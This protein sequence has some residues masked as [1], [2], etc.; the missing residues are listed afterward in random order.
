MPGRTRPAT[1]TPARGQASRADRAVSDPQLTPMMEQYARLKARA[2]EALLFFRMGDFYELFHDD[3]VVAAEALNITLTSRQKHQGEP[4]PMCGVPYHSA[5]G[6]LDRLLKQGMK[7]A[8]AEQVEDPRHADGLVKRDIIRVVTPG[9]VVSANSLD[10]KLH[11]FLACI[12]ATPSGAGFA[13]VDISTGTFAVT[14]WT[15]GDSWQQP[16]RAEYERVQ[17]REVLVPEPL[18][19]PLDVFDQPSD[20]FPNIFQPWDAQ[21]FNLNRAYRCLTR[22]FAVRSLEGFGCDEQPLAITAAGALL[23]Y[24]HETQQNEMAHLQGLNYYSTGN[25]MALDDT[26]RQNLDLLPTSASHG[27]GGS[28][29]DVIDATVTAMGGRLLRDWLS[30]PLCRLEPLQER[31]DAVANVVQQNAMRTQLREAL[32]NVADLERLLG[33]LSLGTIGPRELLALRRSIEALPAVEKALQTADSAA[34]ARFG[35]TW[36]ALADLGD[37]ITEALVD[38]PPAGLRDGW[39]IRSDYCQ[40]LAS[41]RDE[42]TTGKAWL[43]QFEAEER[44]RTGISSLRVG[45][46]K[47]FGYYIEVRKTQLA[48]VPDDYARKQTLVNAERFIVPV[49][50]DREVRMLRAAEEAIGLEHDLYDALVKRLVDNTERLQHMAQVVSQIDVIAALAHTATVRQYCRPALDMT[51]EL[52]IAD[53]RHPVLEVEYQEERFVPNDTYL[54]RDDQ[55]I[56]LLTGPNMA[57]KSTYMR[58]VA[59]NVVL[60]QIGSYVPAREARIGLVDRIFTRVGA[61]DVLSKGQS[62]F[63]VEMTETAHI[64]HN[65]T[66]RSLIL[67]DEIGRGTSTYDGMSIAWAVVEHIHNHRDLR[68]RALFATHYHELTDLAEGLP[69]LHNFNVLVQEEGEK[70]VFLRH[71]VP[72]S[73]DRSYGIQVARLAGLPQSVVGRAGQL[74]AHL[75]SE[76]S[77]DEAGGHGASNRMVES[78][79]RQGAEQMSLFDD[80][81]ARLLD[82]L[83]ATALEELSPLEALNKLAEYRDRARRLP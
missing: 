23:A 65:L 2:G 34:L 37:W 72:G 61:R 74:L 55:Q 8:I 15:S 33:R 75:E 46:N 19:V 82:E 52:S 48:Q 77:R 24:V 54:N 9:T 29:L 1:R 68:P 62:T 3:A 28:L 64:L 69:R 53:G 20:L 83:R 18:T 43:T 10:P 14:T 59:L 71:I 16:L 5:D 50:K 12:A 42:S 36:D 27:S 41:L 17:P 60:A 47:V 26:T 45:F 58:Q 35:S 81:S 13:Y 7:V 67:L 63:M 11:N 40:Q 21:H 76:S 79:N 51:D 70:I 31:Q 32:R 4:I 57:G 56:L 25:Y 66:A 80:V 78:R 38:D 44:A 39:V 30:Q 22:H 49:L 73:A 6:Y